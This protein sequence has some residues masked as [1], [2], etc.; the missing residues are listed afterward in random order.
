MLRTVANRH[1]IPR[2]L[3]LAS[4][5]AA[6][7]VAGC[8]SSSAP[9]AAATGPLGYATDGAGNLARSGNGGCVRTGAWE[10]SLATAE[11]DPQLVAQ[12][13]PQAPV[14]QQQ[15]PEVAA[16]PAEPEPQPLSESPA[17]DAVMPGETAEGPDAAGV[18]PSDTAQAEPPAA[19]PVRIF[20]GTDA[21]FVFDQAELTPKAQDNLDKIVERAQDAEEVTIRIVGFA[22]EIGAEDYNQSLSQRRADAVRVYLIERGIP[23]DAVSVDARGETDPIVRC[24]GRQGGTLIDCLQPNRR[25]EVEFSGLEP[26]QS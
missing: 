1:L 16:A 22:D 15:Q 12:A 6:F 2:A 13:P 9:P 24:E 14:E 19:E 11:C 18:A 25:A 3:R 4:L 21:Y 7:A 10:P 8:A 20:V 17:P 23:A 26:P 5:T